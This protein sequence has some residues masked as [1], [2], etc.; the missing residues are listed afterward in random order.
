MATI[1]GFS[2]SEREIIGKGQFGSVFKGYGEDPSSNDGRVIEVAVKKMD[3]SVYSKKPAVK[4]KVETNINREIEIL[5]LLAHC[6]CI[7]RLV[8]HVVQNEGNTIFLFMELCDDDL[9]GVLARE[10]VFS[11]EEAKNFLCQIAEGM[12]TLRMHKIVHRDLKPGNI[13]IKVDPLT[14]RRLYKI[15]DFGYA[16]SYNPDIPSEVNIEDTKL[17]SVAG[18]VVYMVRV[19]ELFINVTFNLEEICFNLIIQLCNT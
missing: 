12:N 10:G 16:R 15:A 19:L 1:E 5:K 7:V 2:W 9:G 4:K 18:T 17:Y 11:A 14:N 8:K 6:P 3:L 13:L